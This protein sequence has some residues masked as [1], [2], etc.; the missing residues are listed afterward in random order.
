MVADP[1]AKLSRFFGV[2]IAEEGV[3]LRGT[4]IINPKGELAAYEI[5]N[6]DIGRSA[7]ETFRKVQAAK[8]VSEHRGQVCPASWKPGAK[9]LKPGLDLVG[10]I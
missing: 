10:K 6:N 7:A 9:T 3:A 5:N 2:Y 1:T 4:F 8:F